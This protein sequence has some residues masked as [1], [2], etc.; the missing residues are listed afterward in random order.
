MIKHSKKNNKKDMCTYIILLSVLFIIYQIIDIGY[1]PNNLYLSIGMEILIYRAISYL[2]IILFI[3]TLVISIKKK[4]K[5]EETSTSKKGR[6][7]LLLLSICPVIIFGF[8]YIREMYYINNSKLVLV[9]SS[10][11]LYSKEYYGYAINENYLKKI[12]IGIDY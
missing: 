8:S 10:G 1:I 9:C 3:A 11:E 5:L 2:S 6:N 12:S 4:N 7:V